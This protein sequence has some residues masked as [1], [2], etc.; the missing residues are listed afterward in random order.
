M[1]LRF[2]S[3]DLYAQISSPVDPT[4]LSFKLNKLQQAQNSHPADIPDETEEEQGPDSEEQV[5]MEV[6]EAEPMVAEVSRI[7]ISGT[8]DTINMELAFQ[9]NERGSRNGDSNDANLAG[10]D[11]G[12]VQQ[13]PCRHA[14]RIEER[15]EALLESKLNGFREE[16]RTLRAEG[17]ST[18]QAL[19]DKTSELLVLLSHLMDASGKTKKLADAVDEEKS[20]IATNS[21]L[22]VKEKDIVLDH[23]SSKIDQLR[24]K[25]DEIQAVMLPR[26]TDAA[27]LRT[28]ELD[29]TLSHSS[30][31]FKKSDVTIESKQERLLD[32]E[33]LVGE[34]E[35]VSKVSPV[36]SCSCVASALHSPTFSRTGALSRNAGWLLVARNRRGRGYA[37]RASKGDRRASITAEPYGRLSAHERPRGERASSDL[38][39]QQSPR[40][41]VRRSAAPLQGAGGAHGKQ[42]PRGDHS[43]REPRTGTAAGSGVGA[44]GERERG[45]ARG[46]AGVARPGR[47][48]RGAARGGARI[49]A[50]A[51]RR[52]GASCEST[53][54]AVPCRRAITDGRGVVCMVLGARKQA[55]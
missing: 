6:D 18:G 19:Q 1:C 13:N 33:N 11:E 2:P 9:E 47:G 31:Q 32:P 20:M 22:R 48:P 23:I 30:S 16:V 14:V 36:P 41:R 42:R 26:V 43:A 8:D 3:T 24:A 34:L 25:V 54:C 38:R 17:L 27:A 49:V 29:E 53:S 51:A 39:P 28:M 52:E 44:A 46:G 40:V 37:L 5:V 35:T 21:D 15:L 7:V 45:G 4:L 12:E 55:G 50:D 10:E